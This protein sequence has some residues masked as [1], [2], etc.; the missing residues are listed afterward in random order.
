MKTIKKLKKIKK[1]DVK[2]R[3]KIFRCTYHFFLF[4]KNI[5]IRAIFNTLTKYLQ[6]PFGVVYRHM[7]VHLHDPSGDPYPID[8]IVFC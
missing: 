3:E 4:Y 7:L 2:N 8:Q 1:N 6:I 5:I